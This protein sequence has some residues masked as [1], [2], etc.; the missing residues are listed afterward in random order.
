MSIKMN[1]L[2][3][4]K[5]KVIFLVV[6]IKRFSSFLTQKRAFSKTKI[7]QSRPA[8]SYSPP[9]C[10]SGGQKPFSYFKS[11]KNITKITDV[12][13]NDSLATRAPAS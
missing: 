8:T 4:Y 10:C 6:K 12:S 11:G 9:Y 2:R 1:S 13:S 3:S 7:K 5:C